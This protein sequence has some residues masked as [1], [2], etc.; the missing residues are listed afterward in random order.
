MVTMASAAPNRVTGRQPKQAPA[1]T[2]AREAADTNSS[3]IDDVSARIREVPDGA[4]RFLES[5]DATSP[6][7]SAADAGTIEVEP[8]HIEQ[9]NRLLELNRMRLDIVK[10]ETDAP[11]GYR[12]QM[13]QTILEHERRAREEARHATA[14][15]GL[16]VLIAALSL[17]GAFAPCIW[18]LP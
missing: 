5:I 14:V 13:S 10:A 12:R 9:F 8:A 18:P 6:V 4:G 11:D 1:T 2:A 15:N 17:P 16:S 7:K 3:D